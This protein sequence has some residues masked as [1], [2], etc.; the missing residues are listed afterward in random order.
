MKTYLQA[1]A[2]ENHM[3]T[4][5]YYRKPFGT[6]NVAYGLLTVLYLIVGLFGYWKYGEEIRSSITMNFPPKEL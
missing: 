6:L 3:E 2:V 1:M 5:D 4:P